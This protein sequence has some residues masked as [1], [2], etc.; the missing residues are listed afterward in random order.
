MTKKDDDIII[1]PIKLIIGITVGIVALAAAVWL[2]ITYSGGAGNDIAAE[3]QIPEFITIR[4]ETY[5]TDLTVLDLSYKSLRSADIEQLQYMTNLTELWLF[6][7]NIIDVSALSGLTNLTVLLLD[8]NRIDDVSP[9]GSMTKL[10]TLDLWRNQI[11][12]ITPLTGLTELK[13]LWLGQNQ[14]SEE[15][16]NKLKSALSDCEI[17][18]DDGDENTENGEEAACEDRF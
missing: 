15:Q 12:D 6:G 1:I 8:D 11:S 18:F 4:S 7:N 5:S 17:S 10:E 9:L 13:Q 16:Q 14:I 2:I 3:A